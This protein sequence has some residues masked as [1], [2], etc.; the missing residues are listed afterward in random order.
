MALFGS[1]RRS[2]LF[3]IVL[4]LTG[5]ASIAAPRAYPLDSVVDA[6]VRQRAAQDGRVRVIAQL[7]L[8]RGRHVAEG[9]LSHGEIQAQRMDI[10]TTRTQL[11]ARLAGRSHRVLHEYATVPLLAVE[12]SADGLQEL[13]AAGG[14]VQRIHI[15]T[16]N[17]PSL[18]ESVPLT[19]TDQA[20]SRGFDGTG[21]AVAILDTGVD[22]THPFLSG[23]VVEEACYSSTTSSSVSVCPNGQ[24]Q[25]IG[26]GAGV[27]CPVN[28]CYHG[29]HVAGIAAGN[30]AGAGVTFSGMAKGAQIM[31]V[32]IF[33]RFDSASSCGGSPP[34]VL[35]WTSDIIAGL[36][37]VYAVRG[38]RNIAAAN[39]SLGS[40]GA[41][42][43]CDTDPTKPIIDNLRSAGIATVVA[44]GNG[45]L[46]N[47]LNS[48]ACIS[49]AISVGA[50]T[51][52]DGVASFS[53]VSPLMSLFA[54]GV[55]IYSS[56]TGG[57]F[58]YASGTS[59]ATPHVTGAWAVLKQAAPTASVDRVL[60][61][62]Q[63]TGIRISDTRTGGT[64]TKGRINV[65]AAL[66]ALTGTATLTASPTTVAPS[67]VVTAAWSG[68]VAPTPTDWM[69]LFVPGAS[70]GAYRA[71]L[72]VSCSQS[73]GA[74]RAAGAC[75]IPL[76]SGVGPGTYELRLFA[77]NGFARLAT[78][79]TF[80]V[81]APSTVGLS[82]SPTTAAAGA[83]VTATWSSIP[84]PTSTD[85]IG[86]YSPGTGDSSYLAWLYVNCSQSPGAAAAAGSC[87]F[88]LPGAL[89][90]GT[91]EL[92]LFAGNGF[93]RLATSPPFTVTAVAGGVVL[94]ES[95]TTVSAGGSVTAA[96]SGIASPTSTDWIGLFM[97][98]AP[99]TSLLAWNYVG[100]SQTAAAARAA[101]SCPFVIPG[102]IGA[103]TYELRL[104]PN[105]GYTRFAT[106]TSFTVTSTGVSLSATPTSVAAGS[107]VIVT[108]GGIAA[109]S[110]ADWI[111]LYTS[112]APNNSFVGWLYV[113]CSQIPGIARS[114]GACSVPIPSNV[115]A[116]G[117]ELRLFANNGYTSLATS[118]ALVVTR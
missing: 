31:A 68:I 60:S 105:N 66:T 92:R 111:G 71:W 67:G 15:D 38:T 99:D 78:S 90:P 72:Y 54:P 10:A 44:A 91:Y 22:S 13:E 109:P 40:G 113:S 45:G 33:S 5:A 88:P 8:A 43:A 104:F 116:G 73:P 9:V 49:T 79:A 51:K 56:V 25:Q 80:T 89:G 74:A 117:Y 11:L 96:W 50:T 1:H 17:A 3:L 93:T 41:T 37:R 48:P 106:S 24:N 16:L 82:E 114:A 52:S 2:L 26:P 85:W 19:G 94:T 100:C 101:G 64:V 30:G 115:A 87:A 70:D 62:L 118:N 39:L 59:M 58:G 76:P 86:L 14:L 6:E 107:S 57:A 110:A 34:C 77:S 69:G 21:R 112:G 47:G 65:A 103:G 81:V 42:T 102:S 28:G 36:E 12:V 61:A 98:G 18:P 55:N 95:P 32:Q 53:N 35:A 75:A 27:S 4:F 97:P 83:S 29:T 7:Q 63:D 108:W 23:K 20:W 46:T 84:S